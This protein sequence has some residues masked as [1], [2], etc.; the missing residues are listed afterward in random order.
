MP[1]QPDNSQLDLWQDAAKE[2]QPTPHTQKRSPSQSPHSESIIQDSPPPESLF[3]LEATAEVNQ[4]KS[5]NADFAISHPLNLL[6]ADDIEL[7]RTII[8][9]ILKKLGY[10]CQEASNGTEALELQNSERFDYIFMDLD[11]PEMSGI[12][13]ADAIRSEEKRL[14]LPITEIIAVTANVS[15]ITRNACEK[16]G[17]NGYL[18]KPITAARVKEQLTT[19]WPRVKA[20]RDRATKKAAQ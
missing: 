13:A 12:E 3:K 8:R 2:T 18:E 14:S 6:I 10:T 15:D 17:M 7:N 4:A 9:T 11:M 5:L 16:V 1:D 20:R 19:S